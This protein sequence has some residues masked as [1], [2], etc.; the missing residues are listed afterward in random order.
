MDSEAKLEKAKL[1]RILGP[2]G[3]LP[4]TKNGTI[5][6]DV[7]KGVGMFVG[8]SEYRERE[9]VVAMAVANLNA[10]P[11]QLKD[12]VMFTVANVKNALT[13]I[14]DVFKKSVHE[15]V[16]SST[17][18]PGFTLS[19]DF[20]EK[21]ST[22][23]EDLGGVRDISGMKSSKAEDVAATANTTKDEATMTKDIGILLPNAAGS[24]NEQ[25]AV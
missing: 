5:V 24:G 15:V 23:V 11:Q 17:R 1:G 10:T 6:K 14:S 4:N 19:G 16:L 9:S 21:G 12:N 2:K 20:E 3:L 7:T 18:S 13:E 25:L 8:A 22:T